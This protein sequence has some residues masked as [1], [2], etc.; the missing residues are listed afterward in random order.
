METHLPAIAMRGM[1]CDGYFIDIGVPED[2]HR[3]Q[4]ELPGP[5]A[6]RWEV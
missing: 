6:S 3:A 4:E 1:V 5:A 2:Y